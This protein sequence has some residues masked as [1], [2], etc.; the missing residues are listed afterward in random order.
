MCFN[1][2]YSAIFALGGLATLYLT[3]DNQMVKDE[4]LQVPLIFYTLMEILQT[5]QYNFVNEC[6]NKTNI[7][8]TEIAYVLILVQPFMW[9]MIFL[10]KKRDKPI[11]EI[12]KG[13]LYCA[14]ALCVIWMLF[15]LARRFSFYG[16]AIETNNDLMANKTCTFKEDKQHLYWNFKGYESDNNNDANWFMYMTLWLIPALL[17]NYDRQYIAMLVLGI[18]GSK[19]YLMKKNHNPT[20]FASLW[21]LTSIPF[22]I[23]NL[24]Y[25]YNKQNSMGN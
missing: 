17:V 11:S 7:I 16:N 18:L 12:Y 3:K 23:L 10:N 2:K 6:N 8:L 24:A 4:L 1:K 9:N 13:I 14:I 21:C 15:H 25:M 19:Y 20:I 22:L 5:A